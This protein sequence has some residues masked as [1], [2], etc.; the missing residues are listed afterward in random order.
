MAKDCH[1]QLLVTLDK[2]FVTPVI[3]H[4]KNLSEKVIITNEVLLTLS[5]FVNNLTDCGVENDKRNKGLK[6]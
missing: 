5:L 3:L 2:Q 6:F 1:R 4:F